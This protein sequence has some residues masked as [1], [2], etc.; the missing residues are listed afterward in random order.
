MTKAMQIDDHEE[1][2]KRILLPVKMLEEIERAHRGYVLVQTRSTLAAD[3]TS[4]EVFP[5]AMLSQRRG[6]RPDLLMICPLSSATAW[7]YG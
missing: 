6:H 3:N 5:R 4:V 2:S 7:R 1:R